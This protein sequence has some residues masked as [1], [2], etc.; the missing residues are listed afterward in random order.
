MPKHK[1]IPLTLFSIMLVIVIG[2]YALIVI[3]F[4]KQVNERD[5]QAADYTSKTS[6][7]TVE[8]VQDLCTKLALPAN[9]KRCQPGTTVYA[10]EFF[11]DIKSYVRGLPK[12]K[13]NQEEIEKLL[14]SYKRECSLPTEARNS[15]VSYRCIY[16]LRGDEVSIISVSYRKDGSCDH[17]RASTGGS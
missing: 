2:C 4:L 8:V 15:E 17:I 6:P 1:L 5:R 14:G 9:D 12:E 11:L 3:P 7:L 16:D 13:S 10:P